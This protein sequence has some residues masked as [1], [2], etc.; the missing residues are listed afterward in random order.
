MYYQYELTHF[1]GDMGHG[2]AS[3]DCARSASHVTNDKIP[4]DKKAS[5]LAFMKSAASVWKNFR[6]QIDASG[7]SL[8]ASDPQRNIP[9]HRS[10]LALTQV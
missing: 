3:D 2:V 9:K 10:L 6:R 4:S 8:A 5:F 7:R 1:K